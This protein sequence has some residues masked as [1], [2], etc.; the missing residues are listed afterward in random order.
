MRIVYLRSSKPGLEWFL[1]Y[2]GKVFPEGES[3]ALAR[4]DAMERWL[5]ASPHV[6]QMIGEGEARI[7]PITRTPFGIIYRVK[8]D[9]IR[10]M[11]IIDY[12]SS[13]SREG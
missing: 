10:V 1:K 4:F 12:R 11:K 13:Q 8:G 2:Y 7:M 9:H 6:G 3:N 5:K